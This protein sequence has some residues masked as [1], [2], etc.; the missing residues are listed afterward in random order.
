MDTASHESSGAHL[1][2]IL[3]CFPWPIPED[4]SDVHLE[5][6]GPISWALVVT[7]GLLRAELGQDLLREVLSS[8]LI[9]PNGRPE[10]RKILFVRLS[11]S[12]S[13]S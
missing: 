10:M 12:M 9:A 3:Y 7:A 13:M 6:S 1:G 5:L 11:I 2:H 8:A 4:F